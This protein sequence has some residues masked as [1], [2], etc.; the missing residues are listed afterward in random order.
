MIVDEKS[1]KIFKH[2]E[3][4]EKLGFINSTC[5]TCQNV[6]YPGLLKGML[7]SNIFAPSHKA[8][9]R[10]ESGKRPHCTCDVCF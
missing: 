4:M 1:A 8:S 5:K 9:N 6:F 2:I 3:E 10:C 7:L